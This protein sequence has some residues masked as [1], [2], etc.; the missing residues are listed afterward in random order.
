M[1]YQRGSL[2]QVE[3]KDGL[4]WILR[5][6]INRPDGSRAEN[7]ETVGLVK[8]FPKESSARRE[9]DRLGILVKINADVQAGRIKFHAL[10]EHY[11]SVEFSENAIRPKSVNTKPIVEHYVR[12]YLVPNWGETI[13]EDIRPL[14]I[15]SWLQAL[16]TGKGLAWPTV[17]KIRGIMSRIFKIGVLHEL[18]SRNPV[19]GVETRTKSAYVAVVISPQ[20]TLSILDSLQSLLHRTLV[21]TCAATGLRASEILALRWQD[22]EWKDSRIRVSKR[23]AKGEDG[24]T[25]TKA[26]DG[27][28]PM[29]KLLAQCLGDWRCETPYA[30]DSDFVFPSF[31]SNGAKP[32][33]ASVFVADY[34]RPAAIKAGVAIVEGQR[35]GLHNLRHSLSN[36]LVNKGKVSPK[37]VQSILRHSK[38][39][40][41]LDLYT[42]GDHD[43]TLQAQ[44]KFLEALGAEA[45]TVQ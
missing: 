10:A 38:I 28:V 40:T 30:K 1:A 42:Q 25:K 11:L 21:L 33:C 24:E 39:Q 36:W 35:F 32:I 7:T 34:L 19:E 5:Y 8:N 4:T 14:D 9:V 41:T 29:H 12:D 26:S 22:I 27:Y 18:V 20:Q 45:T 44:G 3:R 37:T 2:K 6:R 17:A 31:R 16:H 43:E 23:W 13:A 15:Q